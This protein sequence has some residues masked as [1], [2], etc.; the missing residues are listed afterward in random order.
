MSGPP[1]RAIKMT[2]STGLYIIHP[3]AVASK[4]VM[5][6]KENCMLAKPRL[7]GPRTAGWSSTE[8]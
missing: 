6:A 1:A 5:S 8:K 3:D 7:R 2:P 4:V